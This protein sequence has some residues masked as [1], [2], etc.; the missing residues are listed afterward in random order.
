LASDL[1]ASI[2]SFPWPGVEKP[3]SGNA[4]QEPGSN[5]LHGKQSWIPW[6]FASVLFSIA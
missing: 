2:S 1:V 5:C 6:M 4:G 3:F